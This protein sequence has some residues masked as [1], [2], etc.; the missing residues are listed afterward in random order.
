LLKE[1]EMDAYKVFAS[2]F[3]KLIKFNG[4]ENK[5]TLQREEVVKLLTDMAFVHAS[6]LNMQFN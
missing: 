2:E 3:D 6:K 5:K 4:F 1:D